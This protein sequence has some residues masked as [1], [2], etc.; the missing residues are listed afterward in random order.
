MMWRGFVCV[1]FFSAVNDDVFHDS[2]AEHTAKLSNIIKLYFYLYF[3]ICTSNEIHASNFTVAGYD[4]LVMRTTSGAHAIT[5]TSLSTV[6][7][8]FVARLLLS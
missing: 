6:L 8:L 5:F 2:C 7:V 3:T 4:A 1:L